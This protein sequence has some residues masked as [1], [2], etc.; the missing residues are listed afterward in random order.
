ME[1]HGNSSKSY[2]QS[3]S[4]SHVKVNN[5]FNNSYKLVQSSTKCQSPKSGYSFCRPEGV[6]TVDCR[7]PHHHVLPRLSASCEV[8]GISPPKS[9]RKYGQKTLRSGELH[10]LPCTYLHAFATATYCNHLSQLV[11][12]FN[13]IIIPWKQELLCQWVDSVGKLRGRTSMAERRKQN[14]HKNGT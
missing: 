14:R 10:P 13:S 7:C 8:V 6:Q 12:F 4:W 2:T 5:D 9:L 11:V 3:L 1:I